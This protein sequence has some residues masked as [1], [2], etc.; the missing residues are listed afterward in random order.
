MRSP[1][2]FPPRTGHTPKGLKSLG[3]EKTKPFPRN[4]PQAWAGKVSREVLDHQPFNAT[5][6]NDE[7]PTEKQAVPA[8]FVNPPLPK[9]P[10]ATARAIVAL[11]SSLVGNRQSPGEE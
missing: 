6:A 7:G 9:Q 3:T 1:H 10:R 4:A 11:H 5:A 8:S 2:H